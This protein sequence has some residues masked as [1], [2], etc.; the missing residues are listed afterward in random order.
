MINKFRH[1]GIIANTAMMEGSRKQIFHVLMLFSIG[2][3]AVSIMLGR[4]GKNVQIQTIEDMCSAV[5]LISSALI[6]ISL[7]VSSIGQE[8]EQ[9]TIYPILAK[10]IRRWEFV[11]GKFFGVMGTV[12]LGIIIMAIALI[13]ALLA[14]S[15]HVDIGILLVL[16][17]VW[18]ECAILSAIGI[19][20]STVA[21]APL[22]WFLNVFAYLLGSAKFGLHQTLVGGDH[23]NA[24]SLAFGSVIYHLLPNLECFNFK[25]ALVHHLHAPAFYLVQTAVYGMLYTAAILTAASN[26]FARKEL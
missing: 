13:A 2:L 20:L 19:W 21:S 22:A 15:G 4:Y 10:P 3:L 12:A 7:S 17:F 26:V 18:L 9:K 24:L 25:D 23:P 6:A 8:I 16:P 14:Y 5:I 1:I 11:C